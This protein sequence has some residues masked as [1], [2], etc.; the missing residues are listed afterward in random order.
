MA[1]KPFTT[2]QASNEPAGEQGAEL[3]AS[4]KST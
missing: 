3:L 1:G 2:K 4:E